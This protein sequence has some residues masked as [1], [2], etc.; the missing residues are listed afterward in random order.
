VNLRSLVDTL[1]LRMDRI[2]E[3]C[4]EVMEGSEQCKKRC[5]EAV[6]CLG[7]RVY[8]T[9][10]KVQQ[11]MREL[12]KVNEETSDAKREISELQKGDSERCQ[13][14]TESELDMAQLKV[15]VELKETVDLYDVSKLSDDEARAIA[16]RKKISDFYDTGNSKTLRKRSAPLP[17]SSRLW[18]NMT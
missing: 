18:T 11:E 10:S 5:E 12:R 2:D 7:I 9:C 13:K 17:S 1:E 16:E 15:K 14:H 8:G 3:L 4:S 6:A